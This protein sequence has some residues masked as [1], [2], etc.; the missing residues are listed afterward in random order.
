MCTPILAT[1]KEISLDNCPFLTNICSS[2]LG[3]YL[4]RKQLAIAIFKLT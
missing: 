4:L 2:G 1:V 3:H